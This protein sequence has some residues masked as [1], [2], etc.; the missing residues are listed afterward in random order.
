MIEKPLYFVYRNGNKVFEST[1]DELAMR[2]AKTIYDYDME[3]KGDP[4]RY[5]SVRKI[6][7]STH[8]AVV[9]KLGG[10]YGD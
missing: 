7:R 8:S 5:V 9:H 1:D 10:Y 6:I 2:V 3:T 4:Y